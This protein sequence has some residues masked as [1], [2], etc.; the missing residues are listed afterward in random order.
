MTVKR[1]RQPMKYDRATSKNAA[2]AA[3][4]EKFDPFADR[5]ARDLRNS[6]SVALAQALAAGQRDGY[7][8]LARRWREHNPSAACRRYLEDRLERYDRAMAACKDLPD[9]SPT[10]TAGVLWNLGLFFEVHE[11][12][13]RI[14]R[15]AEG[16][17]REALKGL[18]QAAGV[19]VQLEAGR[20]EPAARLAARAAQ[21]LDRWRKNLPEITNLEELLAGLGAHP[22]AACRLAAARPC[23]ATADRQ[24]GLNIRRKPDQG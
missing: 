14:W 22:A 20:P 3:D 2:P 13:E 19:F 1:K 21:R 5:T 23:R 11:V 10:M 24:A 9:P 6:L 15:V 17:R 7:H 12:V 18:V 16:G 8:Q 4:R